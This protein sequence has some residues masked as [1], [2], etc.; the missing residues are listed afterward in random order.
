MVL[1]PLIKNYLSCFWNNLYR[2][3]HN[4]RIT[5]PAGSGEFMNSFSNRVVNIWNMVP[6][7]PMNLNL[8]LWPGC[9]YPRAKQ[10]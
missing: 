5:V 6:F 2:R 3:G 1:Y 8:Y 7:S 10:F 9:F 4:C